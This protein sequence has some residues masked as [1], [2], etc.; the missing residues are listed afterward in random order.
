MTRFGLCIT[1]IEIT[2]LDQLMMTSVVS[3][4]AIIVIS[5]KTSEI[6]F[7]AEKSDQGIRAKISAL[8]CPI[9]SDRAGQGK[10][11][12]PALQGRAGQGIRAALPCDGL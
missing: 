7:I 4:H 10:I 6:L 8:P 5:S 9:K 1:S 2:Y 12:R 11:F 3:D